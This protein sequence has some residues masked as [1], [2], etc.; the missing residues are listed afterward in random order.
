M[1]TNW[2]PPSGKTPF[3]LLVMVSDLV[4]RNLQGEVSQT[5]VG[6]DEGRLVK[7]L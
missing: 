1:K 4:A 3:S 2:R 6:R 7:V 5:I